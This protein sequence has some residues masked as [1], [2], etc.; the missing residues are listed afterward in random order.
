M[1]SLTE[2]LIPI[3]GLGHVAQIV[4]Q[5]LQIVDLRPNFLSL[6]NEILVQQTLK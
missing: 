6:R 4:T 1:K 2:V 5:H 3:S